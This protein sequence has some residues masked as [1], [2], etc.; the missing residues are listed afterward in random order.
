MTVLL[1]DK[2]HLQLLNMAITF[3]TPGD[4]TPENTFSPTS[5]PNSTENGRTYLWNADKSAWIIQPNA[6]DSG[7]TKII[8][9]D[10]ITINPNSGVGEV[11][12][13]GQAGGGGG[14]ASCSASRS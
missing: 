11:T 3:P 4:Q 2:S 6:L 8:A 5:T 7:T 10:N 13:N 9:G 12:I 1:P 14:S